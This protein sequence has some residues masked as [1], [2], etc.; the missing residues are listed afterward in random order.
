MRSTMQ[1]TPLSIATIVRYGTTVHGGSEVL[2]WTG[3]GVRTRTYAE[4]GRRAA[5]L[6]NALRGL[7]VN[8]DE[9]VATFMW[10]NQEHLE[11]YLAVP[12]MGAVLHTLNIRLFPDQL[13][14]IA[15]HAEDKVSSSTA[16]WCRCWRRC[17]AQLTTVEHVVV[18]GPADSSVLEGAGAEVHAYADAAGGP[19]RGRSTGPR[20]TRRRRGACATRA[21]PPA[22]RRAWPTRHRSIWLHSMQV[23]MA[24]AFASTQARQGRWRSCRSSTRWR[25]AC[26]TP[27][28]WAGRRC[29][30]PDRFLQAE[31]LAAMIESSGRRSPA[32]VPTIWTDL[33][34]YLDEHAARHL[35]AARGRHRRVG[36]ARRR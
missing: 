34:R 32:A 13:T 33:L 6:A 19:A 1:E 8:G 25:G 14:Y 17:S 27:R 29:V 15:D 21:A 23:C 5:R 28:S 4:V 22:T 35:V 26:R 36:R 12:A 18:N 31:P 10:N 3:D 9:R 7:G 30:M 11:A 16:R 24:D 20:S 2:T